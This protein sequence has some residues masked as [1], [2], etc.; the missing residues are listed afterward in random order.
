[1]LW[2]FRVLVFLWNH[3]Y[4]LI[5]PAILLPLFTLSWTLSRPTLYI[6]TTTLQLD[7]SVADSPMF[8]HLTQTGNDH[9]LMDILTSESVLKDT[10]AET[11]TAINPDYLLLRA[12][13]ERLIQ[14]VY[15]SDYRDGL[16]QT[17]D[18]LAL[19]FIHEI[20]A[21][22]R[23]RTE[24]KLQD[25][26]DKIKSYKTGL[27]KTADTLK[28]LKEQVNSRISASVQAYEQKRDAFT[29]QQERLETQ[30][31]IAQ[32]DYESLLSSLQVLAAP[33]S[34]DGLSTSGVLWF[35]E[36]TMVVDPA[37]DKT[38]YIEN[39][40][41]AF[42]L[43]LFIGILLVLLKKLTDRS[44]RRDDEITKFTGARVLGRLPALN[45]V[46][47][48]QNEITTRPERKVSA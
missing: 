45:Y 25:L 8:K 29:F 6:A 19:N 27:E 18:T 32:E 1:M 47:I 15:K 22:E 16:E 23:F 37:G 30:L 12:L 39:V 40:A 38:L 3:R 13:D 9:V 10:E 17:L 33:Q 14:I 43:G 11:G 46:Q 20:L 48:E 36:P 34:A 21:P 28:E 31:K 35:A 2:F 42:Y 24:Q 4:R 5:L 41:D 44:L 7:L 26:E